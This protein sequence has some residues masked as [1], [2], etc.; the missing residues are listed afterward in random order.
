LRVVIKDKAPAYIRIGKK[1]EPDIYTSPPDINIGESVVIRPGVDL[2]ILAAGNMMAP[3][4]QAA[5]ILSDENI[6]VEVVSFYS[7]KPLDIEYL[8]KASRRFPLIVTVEEHGLIGGL[9]GAVAEWKSDLNADFEHL[10]FGTRDEFMHLVGSQDYA[11]NIFGLTAENIA[12]KIKSAL[13]QRA[14]I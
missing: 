3:S 5:Q 7:L 12:E 13:R 6:S 8:S 11:R 9:G 4:L 14:N 10:R 2:A 1:G